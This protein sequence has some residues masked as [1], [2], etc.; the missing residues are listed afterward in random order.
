V[1]GSRE[2][3]LGAQKATVR[4]HVCPMQVGGRVGVEGSVGHG[5]HT[6]LKNTQMP[7]KYCSSMLVVSASLSAAT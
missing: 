3:G 2:S 5:T 7:R 1:A 6:S 4:V